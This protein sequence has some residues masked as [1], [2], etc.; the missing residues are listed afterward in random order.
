MI[1]NLSPFFIVAIKIFGFDIYNI[2]RDN[3]F[4][5]WV[6]NFSVKSIK[7]KTMRE[8]I[9]YRDAMQ[10]KIYCSNVTQNDS[11]SRFTL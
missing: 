6:R 3:F 1:L 11:V 2:L 10:L 4:E 9:I 7:S 8:G 5:K